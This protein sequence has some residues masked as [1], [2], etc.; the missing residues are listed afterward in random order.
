MLAQYVA[1]LDAVFM[2]PDSKRAKCRSEH[3]LKNIRVTHIFKM[4]KHTHGAY[5]FRVLPVC[6][7]D[8]LEQR[9]DVKTKSGYSTIGLSTDILYLAL[10]LSF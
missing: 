9:F 7:V 1:Q 2:V 10:H 8:F 6:A 3:Y 5:R 4:N